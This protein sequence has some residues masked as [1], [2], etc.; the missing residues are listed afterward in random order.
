MIMSSKNNIHSCLVVTY[1][2]VPTTQYQTVEGGGM[3]AWGLAKGL[4]ANGVSVAVAINSSFPQNLSEYEGVKLLNWSLDEPF[5]D[6]T[7]TYDTVIMSY[8]M[9]DPSVFVVDHLLPSVQLVLDVYV[10]IYVEVSARDSNNKLAE[11]SAYMA[12]VARH[13]K[14]LKR[15]DFFLCANEAQKV[16][17][18]GVLG[19]LGIVNPLSYRQDRIKI[20]PFGIHSTPPKLGMNP[21]QKLGIKKTDKTILWFGG[22]YPWF[23]IE[24][25]LE[26]IQILSKKDSSIKFV[27]V[28]GKNPFNNNPDLLRQYKAT[29]AFA[30]EHNL[31]NK[32]VFFVDWV[33]YDT[34]IDWYKYADFVISIN[35]PGE[36]NA[37]A[38]RTRVMDY[39]WGELV[40]L[41]NGGDP[42]GNEL[43][44]N[45]AA[46]YLP[47]LGSATITDT[48]ENIYKKPILLKEA[49]TALAKLKPKYYW[50]NITANLSKIIASHSLPYSDE[51]NFISINNLFDDTAQNTVVTSRRRRPHHI[52]GA[53]KNPRGIL[54]HAREKGIRRSIRL[55]KDIVQNQLKKRI[56]AP[57]QFVFISH[58]IDNTGAP[59]V[60]LQI[61][62]EVIVKYGPSNVR[63]ITPF[64]DNKILRTLR[65]K[66]IKVE[67]AAHMNYGLTAAQL[68][69]SKNDFVFMNTVAVY[70]NYRDVILR[71]LSIDHINRVGW[72]IHED[73]NQLKVVKPQLELK[74]EAKRIGELIEENK[75]DIFVPSKRVKLFYD[76]LFNTNCVINIPLHVDVP[77][78]MQRKRTSN[79]YEK[80]D[81]YLSGTPSDG[82]KGQLIALAA[83][84]EFLLKYRA[85]NPK[86]YREFSFHLV[87]VGDDYISQQ[88]KTIGSSTL[89]KRLHTYPQVSREKALEIANSCNA[90]ICCSLNETFALYV[91]EG[92]LMGHIV[93]RNDSAGI[94]EQ[95]VDGKNGYFISSDIPKFAQAIEKILNKNTSTNAVLGKMGLYSQGMMEEY[96]NNKYLKYFNMDN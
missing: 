45:D 64:I 95:L 91:A 71:M 11:Y 32:H 16:F 86:N 35:Q 31:L 62:D 88:I 47:D 57:R 17:Y 83:F 46:L 87:S 58:P 60:L 22:L 52:I 23:R 3:R 65:E 74:T 93:L 26:A 27:I 54:D 29:I 8:C 75:L 38:W 92:M 70:D 63:V 28:G 73:E 96:A 33:N 84:N 43:L 18:T 4:L 82:R 78:N 6:L 79:E 81:F 21:Y 24:E 48:I 34:R 39:I 30:K 67:K 61:I 40:T 19:S 51:R 13:N 10:P 20:V 2:P 69:L 12:D 44:E 77:K 25:L 80:I 36:E 37:F 5:A 9:G 85:K 50:E 1:G 59:L 55:G 68:A 94:D 90:V 72:F 76:K 53:L 7:N 42:L 49:H 41:T 14:V 15:G 66:G 56:I 89:G